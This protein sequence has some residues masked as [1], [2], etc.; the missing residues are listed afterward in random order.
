MVDVSKLIRPGV[1][2]VFAAA[3]IVE[4]LAIKG[5][6][7][8]LSLNGT[9]LGERRDGLVAESSRVSRP[10]VVAS[11]VLSDI[12]LGWTLLS[13]RPTVNLISNVPSSCTHTTNPVPPSLSGPLYRLS[14]SIVKQFPTVT[15]DGSD[16]GIG[17]KIHKRLLEYEHFTA[18]YGRWNCPK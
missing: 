8:A 16:D 10:A 9:W 3:I 18:R 12:L 15:M 17:S 13:T 2:V 14:F 4:V 1:V 7:D 6:G 11:G 5:T